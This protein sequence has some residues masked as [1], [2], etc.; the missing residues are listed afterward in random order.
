MKG[1][2]IVRLVFLKE[3]VK[4]SKVAEELD[5]RPQYLSRKISED[6]WSI[7][8]LERVLNAVGYE[9]YFRKKK[10]DLL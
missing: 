10:D 6:T 1:S 7:D 8:S 3:G 4:T 5:M 9:L 2:M